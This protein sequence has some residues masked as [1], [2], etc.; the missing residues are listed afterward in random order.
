[1]IYPFCPAPVLVLRK[2]CSLNTDVIGFHD[3][4]LPLAVLLSWTALPIII[5][6]GIKLPNT[7]VNVKSTKSGNVTTHV[8]R[9]AWLYPDPRFVMETFDNPP[10][11]VA[12][13]VAPDPDLVDPLNF[14]KVW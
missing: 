12:T 14:G 7:L 6:S 10:E 8:G 13:A 5:S 11:I 9:D 4:T 2:G 3:I 1:M